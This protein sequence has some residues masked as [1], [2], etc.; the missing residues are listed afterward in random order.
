MKLK[1]GLI[2]GLS[3]ELL[4]LISR[5]SVR[6]DAVRRDSEAVGA[7]AVECG[8]KVCARIMYIIAIIRR[9]Y[10]SAVRN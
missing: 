5:V 1:R 6:G 7:A 10:I 8:S 9:T 4:R 2:A 3:W